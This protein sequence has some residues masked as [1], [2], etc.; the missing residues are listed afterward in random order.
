MK[1]FLISL[2][3]VIVTALLTTV[4]FALIFMAIMRI[5]EFID[6]RF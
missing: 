2:G 5:L 4:A 6:E 3:I 1:S